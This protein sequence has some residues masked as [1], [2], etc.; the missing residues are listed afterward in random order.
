MAQ[1]Q[2]I[3]HLGDSTLHETPMKRANTFSKS[4]KPLHQAFQKS[5]KL[6]LLQISAADGAP[7]TG[8]GE[9]F[10]YYLSKHNIHKIKKLYLEFYVNGG[11]NADVIVTSAMN[12]LKEYYI[13]IDGKKYFLFEDVYLDTFNKLRKSTDELNSEKTVMNLSSTYGNGSAVA[14]LA[15]GGT[16]F[17]VELPNPFEQ[18]GM[19]IGLLKNDISLNLEFNSAVQCYISGTAQT[20]AIVANTVKIKV[21]HYVYA[22]HQLELLRKTYNNTLEFSFIHPKYHKKPNLSLTSG[23]VSNNKIET[24]GDDNRLSVGYIIMFRDNTN[25][26]GDGQQTFDAITNIELKKNNKNIFCE[27]ALKPKELEIIV[28]QQLNNTFL[29]NTNAIVFSFGENL[30]ESLNLGNNH[31]VMMFD[32]DIEYYITPASTNTVDVYQMNLLLDSFKVQ[33]RAI[34]H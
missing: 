17:Q 21:L 6:E 34:I 1:T 11:A 7:S 13:D 14:T 30:G 9:K 32:R 10:K 3:N 23:I 25:Y 22:Q 2:I 15:N 18:S 24:V 19:I 16:L 4:I 8:Y 31:G 20:N 26:T 28:N 33:K 12:H 5:G 27:I 29:Q